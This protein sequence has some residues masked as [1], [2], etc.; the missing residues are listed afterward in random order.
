VP[1]ALGGMSFDE[2]GAAELHR[3]ME[4]QKRQNAKKTRK[5]S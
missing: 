3:C 2:S 4:D 5:E 1:T